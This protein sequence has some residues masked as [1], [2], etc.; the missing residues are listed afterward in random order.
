MNHADA[1]TALVDA[2]GWKTSTRDISRAE[3]C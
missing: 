1:V 2:S 3:L